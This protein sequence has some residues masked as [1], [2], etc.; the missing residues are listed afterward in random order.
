MNMKTFAD[1]H[2]PGANV[3]RAAYGHGTLRGM[4]GTDSAATR[5]SGL[6]MRQTLV[7]DNFGRPVGAQKSAWSSGLRHVALQDVKVKINDRLNQPSSGTGI[8]LRNISK[9]STNHQFALFFF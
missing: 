6:V 4:V 9:D 2:V 7:T 8:I 5:S 3:A 1:E